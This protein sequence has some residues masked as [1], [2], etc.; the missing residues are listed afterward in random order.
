MLGAGHTKLIA[1]A[2]LDRAFNAA[3]VRAVMDLDL[4]VPAHLNIAFAEVTRAGPATVCLPHDGATG[5]HSDAFALADFEMDRDHIDPR[6]SPRADLTDIRARTTFFESD[7][8][9]TC[10]A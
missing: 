9:V 3:S 7:S 8:S 1:A 2:L 6:A 10:S 4:P 5:E